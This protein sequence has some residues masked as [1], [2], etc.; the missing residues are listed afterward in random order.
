M[1]SLY[2]LASLWLMALTAAATSATAFIILR[3]AGL[4]REQ[5]QVE[6]LIRLQEAWNSPAILRFRSNWVRDETDLT[7]AEAVLEFLEEFAALKERGV[8]SGALVWEFV[9]GWYAAHYY[10]FSQD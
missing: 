10:A 9:L 3:Q 6:A 8:L 4:L 7:S 1:T 2:H 5:S